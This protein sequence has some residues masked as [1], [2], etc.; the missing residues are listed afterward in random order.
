MKK[1]VPA[2][3]MLLAATGVQAASV[4]DG[5]KGMFYQ[6]IERP[7]EK[8]NNGVQYWIELKRGGSAPARVSNKCEFKSGD[9]IRFHIKPNMDSFAYV[10]LREGSRGEKCVL[11][12]DPR[13]ADNNRLKANVEYAIPADSYLLFDQNPGTERVSLVLARKEVQ[14]DTYAP[15]SFKDKVIVA[16]RMDGSKDLV[17]GSFVV[18]YGEHAMAPTTAPSNEQKVDAVITVVQKNPEDV[19][20]LDVFLDHKQ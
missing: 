14:P 9:Q 1:L 19:L 6:Q 4:V 18:S 15:D 7:A 11:F 10:V 16:S 20:A 8:L 13:H 3:L 17:P 2:I 12:P 5:A